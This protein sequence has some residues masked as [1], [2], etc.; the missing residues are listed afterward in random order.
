MPNLRSKQEASEE[1]GEE[2]TSPKKHQELAEE[3][4]Y[5]R[6]NCGCTPGNV[7]QFHTHTFIPFHR[8]AFLAGL[9][10]EPVKKLLEALEFFQRNCI[11]PE[12]GCFACTALAEFRG[13]K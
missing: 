8:D 1:K 12:C 7:D 3:W 5:E 10:S 4:A 13:E 2:M 9:E 6:N 11:R